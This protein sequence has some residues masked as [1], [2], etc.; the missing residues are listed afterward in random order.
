[1]TFDPLTGIWH[2][3]SSCGHEFGI[4]EARYE[5]TRVVGVEQAR[6]FFHTLCESCLTPEEREEFGL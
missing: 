3:C 1:M 2:G 5:V 4:E 6:P